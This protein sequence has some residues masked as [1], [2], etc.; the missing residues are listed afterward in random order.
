MLKIVKKNT[1]AIVSDL[2]CFLSYFVKSFAR[3]NSNILAHDNWYLMGEPR[4]LFV[5]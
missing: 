4:V 5:A 3:F 1:C 2:C